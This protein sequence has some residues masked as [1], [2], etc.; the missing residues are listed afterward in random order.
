MYKC[1][2]NLAPHYLSD[3]INRMD[4][5]NPY[6]TRSSSACNVQI[7]TFRTEKFKQ[8]FSVNGANIWNS[9]PETVKNSKSVIQFKLN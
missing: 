1:I 6:P 5:I 7:P 2:N 8:S 3:Q 9:L 4:D